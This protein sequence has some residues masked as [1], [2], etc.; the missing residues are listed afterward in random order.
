MKF[1]PTVFV[2]LSALGGVSHSSA[3]L[4][5][6]TV[7][8]KINL[9]VDYVTGAVIQGSNGTAVTAKYVFE[10]DNLTQNTAPTGSDAFSTK[11]GC[12]HLSSTTGDCL[13]PEYDFGPLAALALKEATFETTFGSFNYLPANLAFIE[14]TIKK[15][16]SSGDWTMNSDAITAIGKLETFGFNPAEVRGTTAD[17]YLRGLADVNLGE[18]PVDFDAST[19]GANS[20]GQFSYFSQSCPSGDCAYTAGVTFAFSLTTISVFP[21]PDVDPDTDP[22]PIPTPGTLA[23]LGAGL[24]ASGALRRRTSMRA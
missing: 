14:T 6:V 19:F 7:T 18:G 13:G 24:L 8:G 22:E 9:A 5:T 3:A 2:A 15:T 11:S 10:T 1:L 21:R 23:L 4:I 17:L 12:S 20:M 16:E